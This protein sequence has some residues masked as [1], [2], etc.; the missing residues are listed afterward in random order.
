ME[1]FCQIVLKE[2]H[3]DGTQRRIL[4]LGDFEVQAEIETII[5]A[6]QIVQII[7]KIV[8]KWNRPVVDVII[9]LLPQKF[10]TIFWDAPELSWAYNSLQHRNPLL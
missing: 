2:T 7:D 9:V 10:H 1:I 4:K 3:K 5:F 6:S 8:V